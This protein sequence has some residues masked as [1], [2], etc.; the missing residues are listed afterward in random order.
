VSSA[1][2]ASS[3]FVRINVNVYKEVDENVNLYQGAEFAEF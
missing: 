2:K 3:F 1:T